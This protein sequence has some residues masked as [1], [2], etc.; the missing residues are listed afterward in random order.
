MITN[1]LRMTV[2]RKDLLWLLAGFLVVAVLGAMEDWYG[3]FEYYGDAISYLEISRAITHGDW[4]LTF[5]P[6]WSLGYPLILVATRW[7]F[8][9][10]LEGEWTAIHVVNL[11][12]FLAAYA[13]FLRLLKVSMSYLARVSGEDAAGSSPR[14]AYVLGTT[15]FILLQ[16]LIKNVSQISPDLLVSCL[17]FLATTEGLIFALRPRR[18]T[19]V[20]LGLLMGLGY[21]AKAAFLP[22]SAML[23]C[24]AALHVVTRPAGERMATFC[25]L[26]WA[27]PAFALVAL[28]YIVALSMNVGFFTLGETGSLNYAWSV[29]HLPSWTHWQGG[30]EPLGRPIHP[31]Q[32]VLTDPH[33]FVFAEPFHVTYPPWFNSF[34]WYE[35]YHRYFDWKNQLD[36]CKYNFLHLSRF[37]L[38][39]PETLVGVAMM[40]VAFFLL[41]ERRTWWRRVLKLWPLY[42]PSV[43]AIGVYLCVVVE[44]RYVVGFLIILLT[45]PFLALLVPTRLVA[46]EVAGVMVFFVV[47]GSAGFLAETERPALHRLAHGESYTAEEKW[48][49]GLYLIHSGVTPGEKV[50]MVG[51]AGTP[52]CTWAYISGV[53]IVAEIGDNVVAPREQQADFI[54]FTHILEKQKIVFDLFRRAGAS[55]V[56]VL[57]VDEAGMEGDGWEHVPGTHVWVH[58]L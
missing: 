24:V 11:L 16:L 46:K 52:N 58:R 56:V 53:H 41:K 30:P 45:T 3:R 9:S 39:G 42:L 21:I 43:L 7:M 20:R 50:A 35:G 27:L 22:L 1:P 34:Y 36:A 31:T 51:P 4:T 33:V 28:P 18:G 57:D 13:G 54:I 29:N 5:S 12:I 26:A 55:L 25:K 40:G 38:R 23:F 47:I 15:I 2:H 48:Q 6:Y 19:A 17:F 8:P 10:G 44:P 32:M 14:S 49:T 37:F